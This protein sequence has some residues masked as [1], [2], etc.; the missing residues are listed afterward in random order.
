MR[1]GNLPSIRRLPVYLHIL[2]EF[3]DSGT[4]VTSAPALAA[5]TGLVA[6]VVRKD[7]EM[8]GVVG[9]TG[10]GD[11]VDKLIAGIEAFLG[12]DNPRDAFLVGVGRL[13]ATIL[14]CEE[15]RAQGL[16][17]VAAFDSDPE[18]I[19]TTVHGVKV[20]AP[21]AFTRLARRM[22]VGVG[23]LTVPNA[24]AQKMTDIMVKSGIVRIWSFAGTVLSVPGHV[25]VRREDFSAGLAEL[26]ARTVVKV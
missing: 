3:R 18:K 21:A 13:G 14:G 7:L 4:A 8:T 22:H 5:A 20:L 1:V 25:V 17:I 26:L 15:F 16:N 9:T 10:I 23:I 12:W 6:S 11:D 19:G 24:D 2:R